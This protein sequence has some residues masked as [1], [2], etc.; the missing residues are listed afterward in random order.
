MLGW[1]VQYNNSIK[2]K[3][4]VYIASILLFCEKIKS[5]IMVVEEEEMLCFYE[6]FYLEKGS[7]TKTVYW[8]QTL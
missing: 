8:W 5:T 4:L 2:T 3:S 7:K 1:N 6:R